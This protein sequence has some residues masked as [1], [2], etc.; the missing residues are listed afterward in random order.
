MIYMEELGE[1]SFY[2]LSRKDL[3]K[4]MTFLHEDVIHLSNHNVLIEDLDLKNTVFHK[5]IYI[6]DPGSFQ[7][8]KSLKEDNNIRIYGINMDTLNEYL[9]YKIIKRCC[10][11]VSK[12]NMIVTKGMVYSIKRDMKEKNMDALTYLMNGMEYDSMLELA[13]H[14]YN[15]LK[16]GSKEES[17]GKQKVKN[18]IR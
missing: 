16:F 8:D 11:I 12:S 4:E 1:D 17:V 9:L 7:I 14:K 15:K 13:T 5:G 18:I 6:V 2:T 3:S 10:L